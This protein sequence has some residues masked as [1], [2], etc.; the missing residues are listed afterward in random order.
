MCYIRTDRSTSTVCKEQQGINKKTAP[1]RKPQ[2]KHKA[3]A[4]Q[5]EKKMATKKDKPTSLR[6]QA[7]PTLAASFRGTGV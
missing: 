4:S 6:L 1:K 2:T 5:K 7:G 3:G